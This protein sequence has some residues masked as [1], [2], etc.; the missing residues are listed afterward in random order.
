MLK[1]APDHHDAELILKLYDLR[2]EAVMRESR[3]AINAKFWPRNAE[4]AVAVTVTEHPLNLAY[5]QT[6]TVDA[7][8]PG[9]HPGINPNVDMRSPKGG[10]ELLVIL[11][12]LQF[13]DHEVRKHRLST[14]ARFNNCV[15]FR[16]DRE[17]VAAM[18][19]L[20]TIGCP[21]Q[22]E[23][24]LVNQ[25]CRLDCL[26]WLLVRKPGSSQLAEFVVYQREKLIRRSRITRLELRQNMG[27]VG[28]AGETATG[29]DEKAQ[30]TLPPRWANVELSRGRA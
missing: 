6:S 24:C 28:H 4:E 17:E 18:V 11:K 21:D 13:G 29:M 20:G 10:Y 9:L 26:T 2:R 8:R 27:D 7:R 15:T 23:V 5:R 1:E 3:N 25:C 22:P 16:Q 14:P 19:P 30:V 12:R